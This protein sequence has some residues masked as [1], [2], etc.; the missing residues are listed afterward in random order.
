VEKEEDPIN[1]LL[2]LLLPYIPL[3]GG[4]SRAHPAIS[5][6]LSLS[7]AFFPSSSLTTVFP[8][9]KQHTR[10]HFL[11]HTITSSP[12]LHHFL[13]LFSFFFLGNA[14]PFSLVLKPTHM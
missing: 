10:T 6:W 12:R 4:P 13:G 7:L 2:L 14:S 8:P 9:S 11:Y 5:K 3:P 1:S